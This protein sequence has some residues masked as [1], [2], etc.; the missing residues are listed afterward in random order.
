MVLM[1]SMH[2]QSRIG[3]HHKHGADV[4]NAPSAQCVTHDLGGHPLEKQQLITLP[5]DLS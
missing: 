1:K 5:R 3:P 2:P 4:I